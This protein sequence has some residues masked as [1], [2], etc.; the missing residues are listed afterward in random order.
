MDSF[1]VALREELKD[2][3]VSVTLLMPGATETRFF[4]RAG[5][6]DTKIGQSEKDDPASV[7]KTASRR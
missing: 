4:E 3:G 2:S 6:Q 5:M 7:A 1:T